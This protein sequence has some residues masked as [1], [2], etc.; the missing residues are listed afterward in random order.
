M[1]AFERRTGRR[2]VEHFDLIT[3]TSTGGIIA[4]GLAMGAT[5]DE[6]CEGERGHALRPRADRQA[7]LKPLALSASGHE[8]M[9]KERT[10]IAPTSRLDQ[11]KTGIA[12]ASRPVGKPIDHGVNRS[13]Y[14]EGMT[15]REWPVTGCGE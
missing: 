6:V 8:R 11:E 2:I 3:G 13:G 10:G 14:K 1:A 5:A 12:P 4:I 9:D 7:R 15:G